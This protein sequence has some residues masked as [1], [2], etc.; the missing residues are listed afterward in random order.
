[1]EWASTNKQERLE[2][3]TLESK[4]EKE[5]H[6]LP[7]TN[8]TSSESDS[9]SWTLLDSQELAANSAEQLSLPKEYQGFRELFE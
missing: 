8:Q 9:D 6:S 1:M 7:E 2:V 3:M 4:L 5:W